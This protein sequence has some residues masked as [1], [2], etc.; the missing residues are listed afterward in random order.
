[1]LGFVLRCSAGTD[2]LQGALDPSGTPRHLDFST[3]LACSDCHEQI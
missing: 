1:M 2:V 3:F